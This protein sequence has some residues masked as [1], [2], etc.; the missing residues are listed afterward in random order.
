MLGRCISLAQSPALN[1]W[2]DSGCWSAVRSRW[3]TAWKG[4][5]KAGQAGS[6]LLKLGLPWWLS[7][8]ESTCDAGDL[9]FIPGL[10]RSPGEGKGYPLQY[11]GLED[12]MN[13]IVH[14]VAKSRTGPSNFQC[15]SCYTCYWWS[16]LLRSF[17]QNFL[18]CFNWFTMLYSVSYICIHSL[19]NFS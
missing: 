6:S 15:Y 13:C 18:F 12:S 10:G 7:G 17:R 16:L 14:G 5:A 19:K 11:S 2:A 4:R 1:K 8:E 9:G 3:D